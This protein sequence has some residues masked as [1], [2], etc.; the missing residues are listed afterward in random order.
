MINPVAPFYEFYLTL[1]SGLPAPFS[2][3]VAIT[4]VC[5]IAVVIV[6]VFWRTR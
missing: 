3:F 2:K 1:L 5:F 4:F 6:E